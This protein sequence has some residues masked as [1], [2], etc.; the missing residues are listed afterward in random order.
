MNKFRTLSNGEGILA[1]NYRQLQDIGMRKV[2]VR[3]LD[4]L[5]VL[6]KNMSSVDFIDPN[7]WFWH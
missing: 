7:F 4:L 3:R 5:S 6:K 2:F 1:D